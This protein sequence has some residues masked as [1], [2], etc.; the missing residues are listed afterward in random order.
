MQL[1]NRKSLR[2]LTSQLL[3]LMMSLPEERDQ[4]GV[5]ELRQRYDLS[6]SVPLNPCEYGF[7]SLP[8]L[9]KSLPYLLQVRATLTLASVRMLTSAALMVSKAGSVISRESPSSGAGFTTRSRS[10]NN[11]FTSPGFL[12]GVLLLIIEPCFTENMRV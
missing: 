11:V 7:I 2:A 3:A 12:F 9:L 8:E 6:Y 1:I 10:S 4:L 5:E